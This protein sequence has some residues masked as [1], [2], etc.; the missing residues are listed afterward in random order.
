MKLLNNLLNKIMKN[1]LLI[2]FILIVIVLFLLLNK[3]EK[4]N[5]ENKEI[6]GSST[7]E[8]SNSSTVSSNEVKL[9]CIQ[10]DDNKYSCYNVNY[11]VNPES[12]TEETKESSTEETKEISTEE[13]A[14]QENTIKENSKEENITT[15]ETDLRKGENTKLNNIDENKNEMDNYDNL[16]KPDKESP[17]P[18]TIIEPTTNILLGMTRGGTSY[19]FNVPRIEQETTTIIRRFDP[20]HVDSKFNIYSNKNKTMNTDNITYL[21]NEPQPYMTSLNL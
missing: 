11:T 18:K 8:A 15:E 20:S 7:E 1:K 17:S 9:S 5:M 14:T 12:S 16:V 21:N 4:E 3:N 13:K 6:S 10:D 2:L 19:P